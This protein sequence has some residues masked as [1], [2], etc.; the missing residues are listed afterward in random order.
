[1]HP[2]PS[3]PSTSTPRLVLVLTIVGALSLPV[4][5][6]QSKTPLD[7]AI[8]FSPPL[9]ITSANSDYRLAPRDLVSFE[10]FEEADTSMLQRVSASGEVNVPMLG[11]VKIGGRTL[12]EAEQQLAL[13]YVAGG[14]FIRPQII[15][16]VQAYAPRSVSI[17]GQ[18]NKPEQIEFPVE[19]DSLGIIQ[20]ITRAGG[21]TRLAKTDEIRVLR[22]TEG[23]EKQYTVNIAAYLDQK[24]GV[25][26]KL[27]PDDLVYVPERI[28]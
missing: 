19:R 17:F 7:S 24:K 13:A 12:R 10:I 23:Q 28:F 11:T 18:V 5:F 21:F 4:L 27:L 15:L 9:A 1:M 20:A 3:L 16:S 6:A 2:T 8:G 14:F 22:V 25:E 26:F